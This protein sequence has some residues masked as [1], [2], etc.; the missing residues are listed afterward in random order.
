MLNLTSDTYFSL[1][2][3]GV[4]CANFSTMNRYLV[5]ID[6]AKPSFRPGQKFYDRVL[7]CFSAA[8]CPFVT[9]GLSVLIAA[10]ELNHNGHFVRSLPLDFP[11]A[12]L[13]TESS[14]SNIEKI[15]PS[16]AAIND[17]D[18]VWSPDFSLLDAFESHTPPSM[19]KMGIKN[20]QVP[21]ESL[22]QLSFDILEW[23][24]L[25]LIKSPR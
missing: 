13:D 16:I 6:L 11:P 9:E 23:I 8:S 25:L 18:H 3:N 1:G 22:R 12:F 4:R 17:M 24:G 14:Q 15:V 2:L 20:N 5:T 7:W 19:N 21:F 10:A